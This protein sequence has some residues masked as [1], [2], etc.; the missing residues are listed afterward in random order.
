[1]EITLKLAPPPDHGLTGRPEWQAL[2]RQYETVTLPLRAAGLVCD[3]ETA[4][5]QNVLYVN[6]PDGSHLSI[7]DEHELPGQLADVNGWRV[8]RGHEDNPNHSGLLYDSTAD[9]EHSRHGADV[10]TMLAA[11]SLSLKALP[12]ADTQNAAVALG[13]LLLA[14]SQRFAVSFVGV[15]GQHIGRGRV[16]TGPFDSLGAAVKEYGWQTHLLED[17]GWQRVHEQGG[18][19]WPLTVWVRRGVLQTVFVS[20]QPLL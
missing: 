9:G 8:V 2:W 7:A 11:I 6:L 1:M 10:V 13:D 4:G 19:E 14:T 5:N 17:D 12:D 3:I 16:I 15:D 20:R 18:T